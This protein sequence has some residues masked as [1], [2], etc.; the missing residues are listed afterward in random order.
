MNDETFD[1]DETDVDEPEVDDT[2]DE[3][4]EA[5]EDATTADDDEGEIGERHVGGP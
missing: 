5:V 2:E 3:P 4:V 1:A